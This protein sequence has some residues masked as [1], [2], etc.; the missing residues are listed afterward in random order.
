[1]VIIGGPGE[2]KTTTAFLIVQCLIDQGDL[3]IE[4]C[5]ILFDPDDLKDVESSEI[6]LLVIDDIFGKHNA[7]VAKY[8]GWSK[9]FATLQTFVSNRKMRIVV[10]S[11]MHIFLEYR[12]K[13]SGL[14]WFSRVVE[15]N[16]NDL[17]ADEKEQ[18]LTAQ[19]KANGRDIETIDIQACITKERLTLG[20]P[21]CA[22]QFAS[23]I[24]FNLNSE[25]CFLKPYKHHLKQN[26]RNLDDQSI[27]ALLFV[28]YK[29][30]NLLAKDLD[31]TKIDK[32]SENMLLHIGRL[33]GIEKPAATLIRDTKLK[34]NSMK[35]SYLRNIRRSYAFLHDTFYETLALIHGE[36]YPSEVVKHCTIDFLC[37]CTHVDRTREE[38]VLVIEEDDFTALAERIVNEVT[39]ENN[40]KRLSTHPVLLNEEFVEELLKVANENEDTLREFLCINIS[41][42]YVGNHAFLYHVISCESNNDIFV[43]AVLPL[44]KC[45]HD[46]SNDDCWKCKVKSEALVAAC[47]TNRQEIYREFVNSGC[48][49]ETLCLYKAVENLDIS[50]DFVKMIYTDIKQGNGLIPDKELLQ[51]CLGLSIQHNDTRVFNVLKE[52]G[53]KVSSEVIYYIVQTGDRSLLSSTIED[54]KKEKIWKPDTMSISRAMVDAL[55][56]DRKDI[57]E[58]LEKAGAKLTEFGVYWAILDH[59]FDVV[60]TVVEHLLKNDTFDVESRDLAWGLAMAIKKKQEDDRIHKRLIN[61]GVLL[62]MSLMGALVEIGQSIDEIKPVVEE[63]KR[64]GRWDAEDYSVAVAYMAARKRPDATLRNF[65]EKEG[66]GITPACLNYAVIRYTDQVDFVMQTLKAADK[67]KLS[68]KYIARAFVWSMECAD[69]TVYSKLVQEG[70]HLSMA[71]LVYAV[72]RFISIPTLE[73]IISCLKSEKMWNANDDFALEALSVANKR[74]D[75]TAYDKLILEGITWRPRSLYVAVESETVY[76][77]RQVINQLRERNILDGANEDVQSAMSLANTLKDKRKHLLL[78][79]MGL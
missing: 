9:F 34:V 57:L 8:N 16:S 72:E 38:G 59:G 21:L 58:V 13:L 65:L 43:N 76:G 54:L 4:R 35:E 17:T 79:E 26:F 52:S 15:L 31:I 51:F 74:Q 29:Q 10:A 11:R 30:N 61:A 25:E 5:A 49:V 22:H 55:V 69:K 75:K 37:Q 70:L 40:G 53:L 36:E 19:L 66:A 6:D 7:E 56:K 42:F 39:K 20:F 67:F 68:N 64:C 44:L 1:M 24:E 47:E 63:L 23:D 12:N 71:C 33:R 50:A 77:L 78:K 3:D 14:E 62:T 48:K 45:D 73:N 41:F 46:N 28:F 60:V 32:E 27:I 2:G 18:I